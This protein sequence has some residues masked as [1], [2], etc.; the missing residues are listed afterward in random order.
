MFLKWFWIVLG[1]Q[2]RDALLMIMQLSSRNVNL[3][4]Y[5]V[6]HTDF[7]PVKFVSKC[8]FLNSNLNVL[9]I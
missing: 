6:D 3:A 7:C 1:Q 5:I 8:E 4:R 2:A 9:C